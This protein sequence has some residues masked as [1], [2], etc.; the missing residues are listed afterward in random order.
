MMENSIYSVISPEGCASIMWRDPNK[1]RTGGA[2]DAHY[3]R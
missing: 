2:G 3:R 1:E